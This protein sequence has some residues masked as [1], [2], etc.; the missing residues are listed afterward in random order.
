MVPKHRMR[1]S[2]TGLLGWVVPMA[3][4]VAAIGVYPTWTLSGRAGLNAQAAAGG[5]V[6]AAMI[7][8]GFFVI[9]SA[10]HGPGPAAMA[11]IVLGM[12]QIGVCA[13][14]IALIISLSDLPAEATLLWF[15]MFF[16]SMFAGEV[17]W[18]VQALARDARRAA[19]GEFRPSGGPTW[20]E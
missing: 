2:F 11:F 7:L 8:G 4:G 3:L 13:S 1:I 6:L 5:I 17:A 15:G 14:M 16:L 19:A 20:D 12:V 10:R 9:R 18:I